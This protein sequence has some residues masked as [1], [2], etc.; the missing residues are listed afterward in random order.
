MR[1][2]LNREHVCE[3]YSTWSNEKMSCI[4]R[5]SN[6]GVLCLISL[7]TFF[8]NLGT[9]CQKTCWYSNFFFYNFI[10]CLGIGIECIR[11]TGGM[12][13]D[14]SFYTMSGFLSIG[15]LALCSNIVCIVIGYLCGKHTREVSPL[16]K[17]D[18]IKIFV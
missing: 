9:K 17:K 11:P 10:V 13:S 1:I 18:E 16:A 2:L 6:V 5:H 14:T 8:I 3:V 4:A 12:I 7:A 15:T